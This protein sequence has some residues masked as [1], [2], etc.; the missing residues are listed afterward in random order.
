M[1][2]TVPVQ[3]RRTSW[4]R[5]WGVVAVTGAV[6]VGA[7]WI[8]GDKPR[9]ILQSVMFAL[10]IAYILVPI[11]IVLAEKPG[12]MHRSTSFLY[13][14]CI[15]VSVAGVVVHCIRM[16]ER[17]DEGKFDFVG[18]SH[19]ILHVLILISVGLFHFANVRIWN[20]KAYQAADRALL[21]SATEATTRDLNAT[22]DAQT[23]PAHS[24]SP[25]AENTRKRFTEKY[26][27]SQE[28]VQG[29]ENGK[30]RT[31]ESNAAAEEAWDDSAPPTPD[32]VLAGERREEED[33]QA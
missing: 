28:R 27:N 22:G 33:S 20:Y 24:E 9:V 26:G 2:E 4:I 25:M 15:A 5:S 8:P 1:Y 7:S 10:M 16:P 18:A 17:F 23:P 29:A 14:F 31:E 3:T 19:Q 11:S 21:P 6:A 13:L 32:T 30:S 12:P